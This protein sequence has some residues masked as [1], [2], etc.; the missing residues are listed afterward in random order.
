[1]AEGTKPIP[2]VL[3]LQTR[4]RRSLVSM[5]Q[6]PLLFAGTLLL[7][8]LLY[9]AVT[10]IVSGEYTTRQFFQQLIFGLAQG[11][12]Y[13]LIALGYTLVYGILF[14][15][16]FAHGEVFTA[17]AYAGFFTVYAFQQS[18][19]LQEHTVAALLITMLA[20]AAA[21]VTVAVTL[22][23]IAYRPLRKAPRLVPLITAIGAS[24]TLQQ[25]YLL[26][27]GA[28]PRR[29]PDVHLYIFP[30]VFKTLECSAVDGVEV[31]LGLDLVGGIYPVD[32]LGMEV[33][34]RPLS[35]VIFALALVIMASLWFV[36]KRTKIGRA[37]RA[38]AEDKNTAA[39][40]GID[41]DM[42]IVTTFVLGALLAGLGAV[43]FVI[44]PGNGQVEPLMGF[45]P[46]IKAF[47]AAVIG[48]IGNVPGAMFGGMFLGV[49]ESVGPSLL[50]ISNQL[51]D[52]VAFGMLI[53]VLIFRPTGFLGEILSE[54]KA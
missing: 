1:M 26:L 9:I 3:S 15:I 14:M 27:F 28:S 4:A 20:G 11:S 16:N 30:N 10:N 23:R 22:E 21:S 36:I 8:Y 31:C 12:I 40:M 51:K 46:G 24:I 5:L 19:F 49:A 42:V 52:V 6:S 35:F 39:L 2:I 50:G 33:R 7:L 44:I 34:L 13:S 37:M 25:L 38:V 17:G 41:V 43:M 45:F 53:L 18:G 54:K 48:G 29:F 47:T 32:I